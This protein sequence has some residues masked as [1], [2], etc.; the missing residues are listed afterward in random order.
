MKCIGFDVTSG[1]ACTRTA[2]RAVT[3][4]CPHEHV[5]TRDLCLAHTADLAEGRMQCGN[6]L[7]ADHS[8]TLTAHDPAAVIVSRRDLVNEI[9]APL[10]LTDD[11]RTQLLSVLLDDPDTS[12]T[13]RPR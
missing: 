10:V 5:A 7:Q 12:P 13:R 3:A 11:E 9:T 1:T 6:C 4:G 8:C 2:A